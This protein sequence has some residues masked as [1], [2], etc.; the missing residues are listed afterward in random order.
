M[1]QPEHRLGIVTGLVF[2]ADIIRATAVGQHT[3]PPFVAC[4]GPGTDR[5][6]HAAED[7]IA[8]GVTHLLSFGIAAGLD[9]AVEAGAAIIAAGFRRPGAPEMASDPAWTDR[10]MRALPGVR[11][12]FIADSRQILVTGD[13]KAELRV[14]T[15]AI[16]ADM[17]SYG[18]AQAAATA[19]V[20]CAALRV[21][22]DGAMQGLPAAVRAG[23]NPDGTV[24]IGAVL[25]ALLKAPGQLPALV[26][27][28]RGTGI[29]RGRLRALA[30]VG[31]A[32]G[33]FAVAVDE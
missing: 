12:G 16:V 8:Q 30:D 3:A 24:N 25:A 18:I 11:T 7:L 22:S 4:A 29:A 28:G 1:S 14:A 26:R 27:V 31:L 10:L 6:R 21:V 2:E 20:P 17:E 33:F 5:A 19:G 9:V 15:A 13:Q 23:A 32:R